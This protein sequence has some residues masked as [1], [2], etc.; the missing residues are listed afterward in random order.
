MCHFGIMYGCTNF[1]RHILRIWR[2]CIDEFSRKRSL[3]VQ[4]GK[5]SLKM[6]KEVGLLQGGGVRGG[7]GGLIE[8]KVIEKIAG[9]LRSAQ[10]E[11]VSSGTK[12]FQDGSDKAVFCSC[13]ANRTTCW[14]T[15]TIFI[16]HSSEWLALTHV[17]YSIVLSKK[18]I[19]LLFSSLSL[20]KPTL[21][22]IIFFAL[23]PPSLHHERVV[24]VYRKYTT[25]HKRKSPWTGY[26]TDWI[27]LENGFNRSL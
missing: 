20:S 8:P 7:V 1:I 26:F 5:I 22:M 27:L 15:F 9:W 16:I 6:D 23:T 3:C 11:Q 14:K 24:C 17:L 18:I 13:L 19:L 21:L 10:S 12:A 2:K 4:N 25:L